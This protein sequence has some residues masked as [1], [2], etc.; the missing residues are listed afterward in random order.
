MPIL[1][2]VR[3][4]QA[5]KVDGNYDELSPLGS[6]Q[7]EA[8]AEYLN[9]R[10]VSFATAYSGTLERQRTTRDVL[11]NNLK[12][13]PS[14]LQ[15]SDSLNEVP[16]QELMKGYCSEHAETE[17]V[18]RLMQATKNER[19]G[20]YFRVLREALR[21]WHSGSL[22]GEFSTWESFEKSVVSWSESIRAQAD[23]GN[24]LAVSSGGTIGTLVAHLLK[25]PRETM[26]E[27]N[28]QVRN[29]AYCELA[30]NAKRMRLISFNAID[31]ISP[32]QRAHLLTSL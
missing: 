29:T 4:G 5:G 21:S 16:F 15:E 28:F 17:L 25:A 14:S 32:S 11:V 1:Y 3:H 30:F 8:L 9:E 10:G 19:A 18:T 31:H 27:L 7:A 6:L 20:Y 2:L 24:I 13:P 26:I 22:V 12:C 23:G